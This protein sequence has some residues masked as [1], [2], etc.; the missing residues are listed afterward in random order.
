[1]SVL[2]NN[3]NGS[4][5][6]DVRLGLGGE[7][8]SIFAAELNGD[9]RAD[10]VVLNNTGEMVV[11]LTNPQGALAAAIDYPTG[12]WPTYQLSALSAPAAIASGDL[13]GDGKPDLIATGTLPYDNEMKL[14]LNQGGGKFGDPMA[15]YAGV[16]S[17]PA[18]LAIADLNGDG[19]PDLVSG[20]DY[21]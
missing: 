3:G 20:D 6:G 9:G 7:P 14:L 13:D 17:S 8:N 4:F 15:L 11:A 1:A 12:L 21:P 2:Y 16:S 19:K 10:L 18:T 5:A